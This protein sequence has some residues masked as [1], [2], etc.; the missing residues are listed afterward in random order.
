MTFTN[1]GTIR[2][3]GTGSPFSGAAS[4]WTNEVG[5]V[6][7]FVGPPAANGSFGGPLTLVNR[8]LL[9]RSAGPA[10]YGFSGAFVNEAGGEIRNETGTFTFNDLTSEPTRATSR[11]PTSRRASPTR[12]AGTTSS[13]AS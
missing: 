13:S 8:G 4:L 2:V 7:D 6:M 1:E 9:V 3:L 5:A 12:S 10:T 11:R